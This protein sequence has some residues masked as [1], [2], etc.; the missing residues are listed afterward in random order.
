MFVEDD[1]EN[2]FLGETLGRNGDVPGN[3]D[4]LPGLDIHG[5]LL[6]MQSLWAVTS[7]TA[8]ISRD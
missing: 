6:G 3:L 1:L 7:Q 2:G 8:M 5:L 4:R